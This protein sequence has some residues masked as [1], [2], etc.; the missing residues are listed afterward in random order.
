MP[1]HGYGPVSNTLSSV[2][3][4]I[5]K[6]VDIPGLRTLFYYITKALSSVANSSLFADLSIFLSTSLIA[7]DSLGPDFVLVLNNTSV[8]ILELTVGFESNI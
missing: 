5:F 1:P 6:M 8:Y 7:G 3:I 4:S 2:A